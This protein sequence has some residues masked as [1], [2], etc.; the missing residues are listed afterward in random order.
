M[1]VRERDALVWGGEPGSLD[2]CVQIVV[3]SAHF[4]L[5]PVVLLAAMKLWITSF[6]KFHLQ[7]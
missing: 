6:I 7:D 3:F 2:R 1:M 4:C 5:L